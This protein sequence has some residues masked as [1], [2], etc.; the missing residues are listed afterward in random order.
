M[1]GAGEFS[2]F[3]VKPSALLDVIGSAL[4]SE[5]LAAEPA[6]APGASQFE[7]HLADEVP[8][9][10]MVVD[11]HPTNRKFC[12]AALR[13]L[14]FEPVLASSGEEAVEVAGQ[15]A[16]DTILMDIEM[17]DMDGI[18]AT[19]KIRALRSRADWPYVVALT[20]NAIAG[21]R[22]KYLHAG[23]DDCVSKSNWSGRCALPPHHG[24]RQT[25]RQRCEEES[26]WV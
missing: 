6:N 17:P 10:I 14:G 12:A 23:M 8:L 15:T 5:L 16:F 2:G 19:A 22:E 1:A 13:K 20:A 4:R 18:E 9:R 7:L 24:W 25:A 11:D 21:D 26:G 3:L